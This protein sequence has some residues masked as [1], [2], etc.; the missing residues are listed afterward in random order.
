MATL[1]R[2]DESGRDRSGASD[3]DEESLATKVVL[4]EL[5][6][7]ARPLSI[8]DLRDRTSLTE[9]TVRS[10]LMALGG[11]GICEE[12]DPGGNRQPRYRLLD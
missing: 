7:A 5:L 1:N 12:T 6:D 4:M 2:V 9:A 11:V 8:G 10:A 3:I